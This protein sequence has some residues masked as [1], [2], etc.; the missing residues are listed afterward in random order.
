MT[1][2]TGSEVQLVGNHGLEIPH[3]LE[4]KSS[5]SRLRLLSP[6]RMRKIDTYL[7]ER[8]KLAEALRQDDIDHGMGANRF[9]RNLDYNGTEGKIVMQAVD[10]FIKDSLITRKDWGNVVLAIGTAVNPLR[11]TQVFAT[12]KHFTEETK[13]KGRK[14]AIEDILVKFE[15]IDPG[16]KERASDESYF[17]KGVLANLATAI[18]DSL[19]KIF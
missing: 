15:E 18:E 1:E 7:S 13:D 3:N 4:V 19:S 5:I 17:S 11:R 6:I 9:F 2:D 14:K 10:G 16:I 8:K 12:L